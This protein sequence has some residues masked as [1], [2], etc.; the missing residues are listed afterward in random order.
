M[1]KPRQRNTINRNIERYI[2]IKQTLP[3]IILLR[4]IVLTCIAWLLF[5]I[6]FYHAFLYIKNSWINYLPNITDQQPVSLKTFMQDIRLYAIIIVLVLVYVSLRLLYNLIQWTNSANRM[7]SLPV[8]S[9][10]EQALHF[11]ASPYQVAA[12]RDN[13]ICTVTIDAETGYVSEIEI[14]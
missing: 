7:V 1:G 11:H 5:V 6:A 4:D 14:N 10:E 3:V 8:V 2:V 13:K 9:V 12:A